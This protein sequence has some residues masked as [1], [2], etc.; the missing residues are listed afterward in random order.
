MDRIVVLLLAIAFLASYVVVHV[1][2]AAMAATTHQQRGVTYEKAQP[3]YT[4]PQ[5]KP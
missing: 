3:S 5:G 4:L 1:V 2:D